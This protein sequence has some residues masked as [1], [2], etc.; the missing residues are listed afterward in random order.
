VPEIRNLSIFS[1][2]ITCACLNAT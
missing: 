2:G 1:V